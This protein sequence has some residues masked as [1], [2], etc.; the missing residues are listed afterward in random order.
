VIHRLRMRW[1][2]RRPFLVRDDRPIRWLVVSDEVDR[3]LGFA[4]NRARLAPID[5]ILGAGD[6]EPDYLGFL[7]D[8]FAAPLAYVRGN[9]DRGGS[10]AASVGLLAPKALTSGHIHRVDG[11]GLAALEWPG[12]RHGDPARHDS[13]AWLD[14]ARI[15]VQYQLRRLTDDGPLVA[16]SH[17]PPLGVGDQP[18]DPYH[19]GFRAYRSLL[20]RIR[21]PLWLH[22][23]IA[24]ATVRDWRVD[25]DGT[26]V[27]N[28][29]PVLLVEILSPA[30]PEP[31][32]ID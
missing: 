21:P 19:I 29:T 27:A 23:H 11:I 31:L 8:A 3:A 22:G 2:D 5:T 1:P 7:A 17:A 12:L 14:A 26:I 4:E 10:W 18:G 28:A 20:D 9:H 24:P 32:A 25:H 15:T 30:G 13:S 16:L 6:L